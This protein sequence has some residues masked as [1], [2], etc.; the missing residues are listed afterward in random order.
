MSY[1]YNT[2]Y[3]QTRNTTSMASNRKFFQPV[4]EMDLYISLN[5]KQPD[6]TY[7][8]RTSLHNDYPTPY[9]PVEEDTTSYSKAPSAWGPHLWYY[10]HSCSFNYPDHPSDEKKNNMKN[11]LRSL[12]ATMPCPSCSQHYKSYMDEAD[13]DKICSSRDNLFKF[14][15]DLHNKV[16]ARTGK[17]EISYDQAYD[18][19][20]GT[21]EEYSTGSRWN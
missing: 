20:K 11:W 5:N 17:K 18:M 4:Q 21:M 8:Y 10:L 13:L 7:L 1:H 2:L 6:D 16:N 15:V 9:V 19:Y 12:Y 3:G 14:I